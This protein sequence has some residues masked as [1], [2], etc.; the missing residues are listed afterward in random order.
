M[1]EMDDYLNTILFNLSAD[2]E[3][4]QAWATM[5]TTLQD[6]PIVMDWWRRS[7]CR[8]GATLAFA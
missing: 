7:S 1:E 3:H 6:V 4:P 2:E 8:A 5:T